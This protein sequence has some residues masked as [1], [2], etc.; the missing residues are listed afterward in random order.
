VHFWN[1]RLTVYGGG[2]WGYGFTAPTAVI[3]WVIKIMVSD[4]RV[5]TNSV[6]TAAAHETNYLIAYFSS[7]G[8]GW[9]ML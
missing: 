6:I 7:Y 1:T 9:M 3:C 2:N 4:T 8:P 5:F